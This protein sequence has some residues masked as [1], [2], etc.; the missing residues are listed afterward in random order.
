METAQAPKQSYPNELTRRE[1]E[2]LRLLVEGLSNE[3]I[4][5]RLFLST[6]TVRSH[7]YSIYSKLGVPNRAAATRF[8]VQHQLV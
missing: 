6:N 2:V 8:A 1:V 7:L 3:Q 4:G 5:E